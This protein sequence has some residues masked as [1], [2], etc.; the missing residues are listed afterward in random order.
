LKNRLILTALITA[1]II[2][3]YGALP[4]FIFK[5]IPL[6]EFIIPFIGLTINV[7]LVWL[8]NIIVTIK[9]YNASLKKR[10]L[11][12]YAFN[13]LF[14]FLLF[15]PIKIFHH[16]DRPKILDSYILYP[17]LA[18]ISITI[19]VFVVCNSILLS[20]KKES[21]EQE[22]QELKL[23]HAEAQKQVLMQH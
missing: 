3:L 20:T 4:L 10:L 23:K 6:K 17:I 5:I 12:T 21:A 2:A 13:F 14:Q 7:L 8:S 1:P 16:Q 15:I 22:V 11:A 19:I 9:L 18:S